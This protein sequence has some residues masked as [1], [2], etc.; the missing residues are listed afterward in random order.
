MFVVFVGGGGGDEVT[1]MVQS[2]SDLRGSV[3]DVAVSKLRKEFG[4]VDWFG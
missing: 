1:L 4:F 3:D 2:G